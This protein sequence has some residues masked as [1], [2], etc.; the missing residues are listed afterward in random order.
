MHTNAL[1]TRAPPETNLQLWLD[2]EG[3]ERMEGEAK[4]REK[5]ENGDREGGIQPSL[6]GNQHIRGNYHQDI[7]DA[8]R[9]HSYRI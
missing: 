9:I 1:E 5:T 8:A 7:L 3:H 2:L 4:C 6:D